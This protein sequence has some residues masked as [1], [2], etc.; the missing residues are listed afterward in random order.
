MKWQFLRIVQSAFPMYFF[1][2]T[3]EQSVAV[4]VQRYRGYLLALLFYGL[5]LLNTKLNDLPWPS[6]EIN[7]EVLDCQKRVQIPV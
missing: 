6:K 5:G 7:Y 1:Q 3:N 2:E 4:A